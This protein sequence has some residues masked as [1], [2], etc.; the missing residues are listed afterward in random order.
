MTITNRAAFDSLSPDLQ[1]AALLLD[2]TADAYN[3]GREDAQRQIGAEADR[4]LAEHYTLA[5]TAQEA[6]MQAAFAQLSP[7]AQR[8]A[9]NLIEYLDRMPDVEG[10]LDLILTG[11]AYEENRRKA[12][13]EIDR[14]LAERF[15]TEYGALSPAVRRLAV[16]IEQDAPPPAPHALD[17]DPVITVVDTGERSGV[18]LE[19]YDW[20][21]TPQTWLEFSA[22]RSPSGEDKPIVMVDV[23]LCG[24][25]RGVGLIV[26]GSEVNGRGAWT[27]DNLRQ[28][29]AALGKLLADPRLAGAVAE[30]HD[31]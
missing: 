12:A 2:Q 1:R 20:D 6:D 22:G 28:L 8:L 30:Q 18:R 29:H 19:R 23:D 17:D 11:I 21:D 4:V 7:D 24:G 5:E 9:N 31:A 13:V 14:A 16:A 25:R 10:T 3:Q 26:D 15:P 27:L